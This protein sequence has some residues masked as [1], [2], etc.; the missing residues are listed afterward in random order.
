M[1]ALREKVDDNFSQVGGAL[2]PQCGRKHDRKTRWRS[3]IWCVTHRLATQ[4]ISGFKSCMVRHD[5]ET[6]HRELS[7]SDVHERG[8]SD[9]GG[10]SRDTRAR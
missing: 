3:M 4:R 8:K 1:G 5:V 9:D 6:R 7:Y 10:G 2:A